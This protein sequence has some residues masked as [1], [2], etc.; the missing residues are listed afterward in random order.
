MMRGEEEDEEIRQEGDDAVALF[1]AYQA[2][3][4]KPN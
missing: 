3:H 4:P 1:R 2:A